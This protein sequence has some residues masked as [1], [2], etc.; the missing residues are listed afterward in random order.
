MSKTVAAILKTAQQT[1]AVN[2]PLQVAA[3]CRVST[4]QKE[5]QR[6]LEAQA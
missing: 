2:Q 1:S 3:Y 5:Q 4:K 6:S